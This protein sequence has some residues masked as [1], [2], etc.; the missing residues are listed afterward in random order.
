MMPA[1]LSIA[2]YRMRY[3]H[4]FSMTELVMVMVII[5]IMA[6]V[7][8]PRFENNAFQNRA[9]A[10]QITA[11]LRYAQK[12]AIASHSSVTVSVSA[13][14]PANCG[15]AI[16]GGVLSCVVDNNVDVGGTTTVVFDFMGRPTPNGSTTTVDS[17]ISITVE[18]ETG[19]VH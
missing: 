11:A 15:I 3:M 4:G 13:G 16:V 12:M 1:V 5:G 17:S 7:T 6:A 10:D 9:A 8:L 2:R 18:A 14:S 19:Y